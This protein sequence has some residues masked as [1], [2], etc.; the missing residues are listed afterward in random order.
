MIVDC[1]FQHGEGT[2]RQPFIGPGDGSVGVDVVFI[3]QV[4]GE[5]GRTERDHFAVVKGLDA[6]HICIVHLLAAVDRDAMEGQ[7]ARPVTV[8]D[9]GFDNR[10][11]RRL[12]DGIVFGP[13][14]CRR[15]D[16][17]MEEPERKGLRQEPAPLIELLQRR[18]GFVFRLFERNDVIGLEHP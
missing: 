2:L 12:K 6:F 13:E 15:R 8:V 14:S 17:G 16:L 1:L 10:F 9:A 7:R 3:G 4:T 11:V 5:I 18:Y